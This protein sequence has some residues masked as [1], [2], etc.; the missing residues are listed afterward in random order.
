MDIR[1]RFARNLR[2][3][4]EAKDLTQE[5]LA[6]EAGL[7]RT[8]ISALERGRYHAS[9]KVI[10]KIAVVLELDPAELLRKDEAPSRTE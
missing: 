3:A 1:Q 7:D 2:A 10:E 9:L 5:E 4:R 6:H 8:Y